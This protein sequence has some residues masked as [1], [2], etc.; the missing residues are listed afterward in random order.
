MPV[1]LLTRSRCKLAARARDRQHGGFRRWR[2]IT[3]PPG[4]ATPA[5][6]GMGAGQ[7]CC[8]LHRVFYASGSIPAGPGRLGPSPRLAPCI[9]FRR[10]TAQTPVAKGADPIGVIAPRRT[11]H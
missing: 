6:N 1:P 2:A 7:A 11:L 4:G 5:A 10:A 9:R 3:A 8:A